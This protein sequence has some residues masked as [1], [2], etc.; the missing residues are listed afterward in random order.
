MALSISQILNISRGSMLSQLLDLDT[1][2]HNLAN[3]NTTGFKTSRSNFQEMLKSSI[4]NGVQIRTTQRFMDQGS[5]KTT[6]NPLDLAIDGDGF[7]A[8]TMPDGSIA[9]SRDGE[10]KL[11]AGRKIVNSTGLPLIW[12]GQIPEDASQVKVQADGT[13]L[14]YNDVEWNRVGSVQLYRFNNP[15]GLKGYGD[16]LWLETEVSGAAQAGIPTSEGYGRI[17]SNALELSNVNIANEISQLIALQRSFE[18]SLRTFQQT[19]QM[20]GLAINLRNG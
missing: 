19:D 10:F 20:L 13:I 7:F 6:S 2:S 8:V 9:Y 11:D 15:N 4:Y 1:V 5:L 17:V 3:I 12:D 18:M 14:A 16:N